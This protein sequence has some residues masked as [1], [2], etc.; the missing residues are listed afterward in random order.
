MNEP[1]PIKDNQKERL[2]EMYEVRDAILNRIS[3]DIVSV[4]DIDTFLQ[5]AVT[6][7]G[8]RLGVDRCNVI[9]P[10]ADGGFRVSHEYLADHS[11]APGTGL[12][13]PPSL[14]PTETIKNYL[15]RGGRHFA[16][17]DIQT[18]ELPSW[19]RRPGWPARFGP[20]TTPDVA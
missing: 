3:P 5:S 2:L 4:I 15:P 8:Q 20:P 14:V 18:A 17:D 11:L 6:E 12:N 16:I 13:I 10:S 1:A 7:V 19:V 9:T